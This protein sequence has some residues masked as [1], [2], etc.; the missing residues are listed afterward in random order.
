MSVEHHLQA[1]T[2]AAYAAGTLPAAMAL[3]VACHTE[4]CVRCRNELRQAEALGGQMLERLPAKP[5]SASA[6]ES[7]LAML[8]DQP[9]PAKPIMPAPTAQQAPLTD[10]VLLP[11]ALK[12]LLGIDH[13]NQLRWCKLA[14][15]IEKFELPLKEGRSFMLRIGAGLSMPVHTHKASELTPVSYTHLTLPTIYPV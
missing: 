13:Y 15:G 5:V 14:P 4:A 12:N 9:A 2:L 6:R 11:R 8:D 1:E 3:V 7:M 10:G